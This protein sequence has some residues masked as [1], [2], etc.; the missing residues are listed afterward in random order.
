M[1]SGGK[2]S[3]NNNIT[4]TNKIISPSA[5]DTIH[6][7]NSPPLNVHTYA[8]LRKTETNQ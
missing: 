5:Y 7:F 8:A 3:L 4:G 2:F 6:H 1:N